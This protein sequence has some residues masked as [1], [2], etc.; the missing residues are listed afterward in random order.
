MK[1]KAAINISPRKELLDPQGKAVKLGLKNLGIESVEDARIGKYI[2]LTVDAS[3]LQEA[4]Q[5]VQKACEKLL[6]NPIMESFS[7]Q[8]IEA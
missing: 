6:V 3:S 4:E 7:F 2:E 5:A 8:I 1:Y